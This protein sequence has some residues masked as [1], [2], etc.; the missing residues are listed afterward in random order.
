M[1]QRES[2]RIRNKE[3]RA[4]VPAGTLT[5]LANQKKLLLA[6]RRKNLLIEK[7]QRLTDVIEEQDVLESH[8]PEVGVR[9]QADSTNNVVQPVEEQL[10]LNSTALKVNEQYSST[11]KRQ[12]GQTKMLA[13]HGRH[14]RKLIV[15]NKAGQPV[16]P[17]NDVVIELSSFLGTLARNATLCPLDIENWKL[18]DTKQDLWDYTKEKYDIPEIG[19]RWT[20]K[21]IQEAWR[22]RK[23]DLK[24][25]HFDAYAND[26]IRMEKKPDDVPT[27]QFKELLKYWNSEKFQFITPIINCG[28][29]STCLNMKMSKAN[30]ENRK[31][32][33]NPHTV[34]KKSFALLHN[35]LE[36]ER[37][38]ND[39]PSPKEFFVVTRKR[40][41]NRSYKDTD[42]DTASKIA[43]MENI[44]M[45]QNEDGNETIDAFASVMGSEHP[46]RLRLYGRGVTKTTLKGKVG[47]FEAS[48]N[49]TNDLVKKME[50]RMLRMEEKI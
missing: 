12:R 26:Q 27:S 10:Q 5:S 17:S 38:T 15:L 30:S 45:Q 37:E 6:K 47:N 33:K 11:K 3:T 21:T 23:F 8:N 46:G 18:L 32:L 2:S 34:G 48:S 31:K 25:H 49:A 44:E 28:N 4:I 36:K 7:R 41:P 40:K 24:T 35:D 19:N 29:H 43:E 50:D 13:V 1:K 39:T 9:I 22:R 16:G 42:E 20:L 14:D